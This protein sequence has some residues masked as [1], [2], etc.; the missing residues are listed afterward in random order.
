MHVVHVNCGIDAE[1][2]G[3]EALL[4]AWPTVP[5]VAEAIAQAGARVTVLQASRFAAEYRH[6][7]VD[8]RF[9]AEPRLSRKYGAGIMPWRLA[10]AARRLAPDVIHLNGLGFPLHLAAITGLGVPVLV[11]DHASAPGGKRGRLRRWSLRGAAGV[12]FTA[13]EQAEEFRRAGELPDALPVF[14]VPES[15]TRFAAGD[16]GAARSSA[17]VWGDPALLWVGRLNANKDPL[18]ILDAI[19]RVLPRLPNLQFWCAYGEA[20]L[21]PAVEQ[22]LRE[23]PA[24]AE[25]VHL[26]GALPHE[27]MEQL[28][29]ACDLFILGSHREGSGYSLIEALACGLGTVVS[30]IPPFRAL[31]GEGKIGA[32]APC[33]DAEAF[34][35]GI[36]T[37]AERP[38]EE[39]RAATLEH[40]ERELSPAALGRKLVETYH[41]AIRAYRSA[42]PRSARET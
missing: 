19:R 40:F 33:G 5:L 37:L 29:R 18:T 7:G 41:A 20:D 6:E 28:Y 12:A 21:L 14:A 1:G 17:G 25:H 23:E 26:L 35:E 42:N 4:R 30:D 3:P 32:L 24:L 15:S 10:A 39:T 31:T 36:M 38:R 22:V 16:R 8:Y 9:I 34:A 13:K 11:Q 2:R 27:K